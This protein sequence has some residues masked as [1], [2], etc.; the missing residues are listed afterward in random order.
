[1]ILYQHI[2]IEMVHHGDIHIFFNVICLREMHQVVCHV[3]VME[4]PTAL[5]L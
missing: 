3:Q 2:L 1:M 5:L 4:A